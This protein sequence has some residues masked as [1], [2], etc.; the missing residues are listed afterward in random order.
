VDGGRSS[1]IR[2]SGFLL[3]ASAKFLF[4]SAKLTLSQSSSFRPEILVEEAIKAL[5]PLLTGWEPAL[6]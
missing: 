1:S 5:A 3:S 4:D 2:S 6:F